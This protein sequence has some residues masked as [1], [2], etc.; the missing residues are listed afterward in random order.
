M[1]P[2]WEPVELPGAE[3]RLCRDFLPP[4]EAQRLFEEL[5]D[6]IASK[7]DRI[8][9]YGKEHP[10]PRLHQWYGDSGLTYKWSGITMHPEPWSPLVQRI[11]AKAEEVAGSPF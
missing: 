11:R 5:R 7:Q 3:V 8:K 2:R 6:G 1:M 9:F 10:V 4:S